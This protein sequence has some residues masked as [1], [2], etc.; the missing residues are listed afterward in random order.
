VLQE[1]GFDVTL[2]E[3]VAHAAASPVAAAIWFPYDVNPPERAIPWALASY[4]TF[5]ELAKNRATG[6][7]MVEFR[8]RGLAVPEWTT[9]AMQ[10]RKIDDGCAI[11]VPLIETPIYLPWLR[12]RVRIEE[13]TIGSFDDLAEFDLIVNCAGLGARDLTNDTDLHPGRGVVLKAPYSGP[14]LFVADVR[15]PLTYI[16]TRRDDVIL[17]GTNDEVEAVTIPDDLVR[18]IHA[19]CTAIEP[20]LPR[21][22]AEVGFRPIRSTV[23]LEREGRVI[24]NYGHG[25]AGFTVSWACAREVLSLAIG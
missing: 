15:D 4:E 13:S 3:S 9:E 25:G 22:V 2:F 20:R 17:G 23:R 19:R 5:G 6:V 11:T 18:A 21:G 7:S 24:H 12:G 1:H 14:P 8:V 16:L 10:A